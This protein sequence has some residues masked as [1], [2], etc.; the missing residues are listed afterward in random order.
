MTELFIMLATTLAAFFL[1][2]PFYSGALLISAFAKT[3]VL[4]TSV[5]SLLFHLVGRAV[6][7]PARLR[8]AWSEM[9]ADWWPLLL[10]CLFVLAGSAYAVYVNGVKESF[11][12][13]GLGML[14]LPL[15]ALS[16]RTAARPMLLMKCMATIYVLLVL[17]MLVLLVSTK[18]LFHESIYMAVPLGA[19]FICASK[20]RVWQLLLGL[21]LIGTCAFSFK[22]TTF[23]VMLV[24]LAGCAAVS[25]ARIFRTRDRLTAITQLYLAILVLAAVTAGIYIAYITFRKELPSGN[26]D[27]RMEM[28]GIAWRHFLSSPIWGSAFTDSSVTYFRLFKVAV[29]TQ[30]L[31]THSDVLDLL[32]QGGTIALA[33]WLGTVWRILSIG[34]ATLRK[35]MSDAPEEDLRPWRWLFVMVL[36]QINAVIVYSFNPPLINPIQGFWIWGGAGVMWALYLQLTR[37]PVEEVRSV[38]A[39]GKTAWA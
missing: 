11:R 2:D 24:T 13:L 28:Y 38:R 36:I 39:T 18:H 31:P 32:S 29:G 8:A 4:V 35:L 33:L 14:F 37:P 34:W 10:L 7:V 23:I 3:V 27:Y 9:V 5:G 12:G 19:Y 1:V 21:A 22:N 17:T 16:V 15:M 6:M 30:Y 26:V 25:V 20:P